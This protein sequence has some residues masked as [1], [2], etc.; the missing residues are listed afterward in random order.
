MIPR[1]RDIISK[2]LKT[3]SY[4]SEEGVFNPTYIE[5]LKKFCYQFLRALKIE[6]PFV[7]MD[8][9]RKVV[10]CGLSD[11]AYIYLTDKK[12]CIVLMESL[13]EWLINADPNFKGAT[14][15]EV[16]ENYIIELN[17]LDKEIIKR[18]KKV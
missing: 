1:N 18:N 12:T 13:N 10:Y 15:D 17:Y 4:W 8:A 11:V 7:E 14:L 6:F 2:A 5:Y 16:G 3:D 9:L